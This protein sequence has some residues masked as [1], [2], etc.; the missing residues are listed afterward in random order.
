[1]ARILGDVDELITAVEHAARGDAEK[2]KTETENRA[3]NILEEARQKADAVRQ[4]ILNRARSEADAKR[5]QRLAQATQS[6]KQSYLTTREEILNQVW[7]QAEDR[8]RELPDDRE[9]YAGVLRQLA[10]LAVRTLGPG[11]LI[12]AADSRGHEL[13]T[14]DRLD[15]WSREASQQFEDSVSFERAA[16]PVDTWGGLLVTETESRRRMDSTFPTRLEIAREEVRDHIFR[17][18]VEES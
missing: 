7:Q 4:E 14:E 13:L 2:R 15:S 1:M 12:L 9:T 17:R 10:W 8:L 16:G 11:H 18:L 6:A 3:D 5:R